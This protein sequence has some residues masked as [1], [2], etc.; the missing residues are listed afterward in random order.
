MCCEGYAPKKCKG[1]SKRIEDKVGGSDGRGCDYKR[2]KI[3]ENQG[4]SFLE[5][6]QLCN[7]WTGVVYDTMM[8]Y[9]A[10]PS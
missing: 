2:T 7:I 5:K 8:F 6:K 4:Q 3:E 1:G 10:S 9:T